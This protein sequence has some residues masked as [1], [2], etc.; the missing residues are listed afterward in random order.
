MNRETG[1]KILECLLSVEVSA[2][3]NK[4]WI[5]GTMGLI[6]ISCLLQGTLLLMENKAIFTDSFLL[7]AHGGDL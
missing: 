6:S 3:I 1:D 7:G 5:N 2:E 4:I